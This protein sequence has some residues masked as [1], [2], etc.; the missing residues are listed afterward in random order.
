MDWI[1][2]DWTGVTDIYRHVSCKNIL[3]EMQKHLFNL[4]YYLL[5]II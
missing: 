5:M 1:R 2:S 4:S 3:L